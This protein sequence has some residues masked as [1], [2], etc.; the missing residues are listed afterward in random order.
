MV[1]ILPNERICLNEIIL[2]LD[3]KKVKSL[4]DNSKFQYKKVELK[5]PKF[6]VDYVVSLKKVSVC[7]ELRTFL[8][9]KVHTLVQCLKMLCSKIV[10]FMCLK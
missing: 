4:K 9:K 3:D 7:W 10:D 8:M 5:L 2:N 6:K 1:I